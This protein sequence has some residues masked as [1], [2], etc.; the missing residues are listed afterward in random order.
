[1]INTRL[2]YGAGDCTYLLALSELLEQKGHEI[3]Y[4]VMKDNRNIATAY[5]KY[6]VSEINYGNLLKKKNLASVTKVISRCFYSLETRKKLRQL[7]EDFRPDIVHIQTLDKH[8]TVSA[9]HEIHR[10]DIPIV[11]TLHI[12]DILCINGI[13][14][15]D[16]NNQ[17]CEDCMGGRFYKSVI[18]CCK[19]GSLGASFLGCAYNYLCRYG[20]FYKLVD[21][22][23]APSHFLKDKYR[24]F[25]VIP[26]KIEVLQN[27]VKTASL[28]LKD[29]SNNSYGIF[30]GRLSKEKG[31]DV[32]L[33][34]LSRIPKVPLKIVG[35]GPLRDEWQQKAWGLGLKNVEFTGHRHSIE[36][37]A[38]ISGALFGV[39]PSIWYENQPFAITEMFAAGKPVIASNLGGM[40]E[41]VQ[42]KETG[43]LFEPGNADDLALCISKLAS[44]PREC[45]AMGRRAYE[46]A[47]KV[48]S[49]ERHVKR[50]LEIYEEAI[51]DHC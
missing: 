13:L 47:R 43:L 14:I 29:A 28:D 40:V 3:A 36:L 8:L 27:F 17:I 38:L 22:Y 9:L 42:H 4:F 18:N 24:E 2:R 41:L 32:L 15:N 5:D 44:N 51:G 34:A 31:G 20:G 1:M 19:K 50:I 35:D 6:F 30:L 11:W 49:P 16:N 25:H 23:I 46:Y 10:H 26:D 33:D 39:V 37:E 45:Q 21:T 7:I 48:L 12:Y